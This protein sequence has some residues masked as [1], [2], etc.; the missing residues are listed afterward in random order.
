VIFVTLQKKKHL[1]TAIRHANWCTTVFSCCVYY[2][3]ILR[4]DT[5]SVLPDTKILRNFVYQK[6]LVH[7]FKIS[8]RTAIR[9]QTWRTIGEF[10]CFLGRSGSKFE[11][12]FTCVLILR[13]FTN[14]PLSP[15]KEFCRN[16]LTLMILM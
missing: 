6:A 2:W 5:P 7:T 14:Y 1:K 9:S 12:L 3:N 8:G 4:Q 15:R 16:L 11:A 13:D 10:R